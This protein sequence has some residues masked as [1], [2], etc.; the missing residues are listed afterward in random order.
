M[1]DMTARAS[2]VACVDAPPVLEAS[3]HDL[4]H[5][6]LVTERWGRGGWR[7][8]DRPI[9]GMRAMMPRAALATADDVQ[10]GVQ[11]SLGA[12]DPT[13]EAQIRA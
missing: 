13:G 1:A 8:S 7:L 5:A 10:L 12:A 6:V 9:G 2:I 3:E 4:D 11:A